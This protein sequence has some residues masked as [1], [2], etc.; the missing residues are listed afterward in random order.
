MKSVYCA[1]RTGDLNVFRGTTICVLQGL[2][3]PF[4]VQVTGTFSDP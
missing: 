2:R 3:P 1:V 4:L